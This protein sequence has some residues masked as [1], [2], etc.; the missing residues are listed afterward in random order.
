ME[1]RIRFLSLNIGMK[2]NLAG[3]TN[4]LVNHK[5]DVVF[6]QEVKIT[7]EEL[8]SKVAR[9][10]YKC[11]VNI[12][13]EDST[14]PGTA[15]AWRSTLL[16]REV[17]TLV[18]CRAQVAFLEEYALLNL[19]APS[20]SDK[21]YERGAFFSQEVFRAF[22]LHPESKWL[23]GGD[24]NC[25]LKP[26]DVENGTGFDQKKCPQLNDLISIKKLKDVYRAVYPLGR[27]FTFFRTCSTFQIGQ[28]LYSC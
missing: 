17:T 28:V 20:G 15:I 14:K 12:N 24:F 16:V 26:I 1:S 5:I 9:F 3:L 7:D 22:N 23:V 13:I 11:K 10:G 4:I 8:E 18:T 19:Y 2:S 27:E 6:L 21:K 25:V